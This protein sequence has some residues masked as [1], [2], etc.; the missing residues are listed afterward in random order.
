LNEKNIFDGVKI[1]DLEEQ[2][3][4]SNSDI[5]PIDQESILEKYYKE[6]DIYTFDNFVVEADIKM[7]QDVK[8]YFNLQIKKFTPS[9]KSKKLQNDT[10]MEVRDFLSDLKVRNDKIDQSIKRKKKVQRFLNSKNRPRD[11]EILYLIK[12]VRKDFIDKE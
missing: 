10:I 12:C 3:K 11:L 2:D 4:Y 8:K 9:L 5:N 7:L 1:D 6:I